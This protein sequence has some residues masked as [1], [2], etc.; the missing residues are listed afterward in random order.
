MYDDA[1]YYYALNPSAQPQTQRRASTL[2]HQ[3]RQ[4]LL[5][6]PAAEVTPSESACRIYADASIQTSS[7][8]NER[9]KAPEPLLEE[10]NTGTPEATVKRRANSYSD[11][12]YAAT[13][14]LGKQTDMKRKNEV[15]DGKPNEEIRTEI[16][17][18]EWYQQLE[19]DVL[20]SSQEQ[21]E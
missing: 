3:R 6:K 5:E 13:A 7:N 10:V 15:T 2:K 4:S 21:Y 8:D 18:V 1:S 9:P 16:D 20:E 12:H 19:N 17:F 14:V 11:F